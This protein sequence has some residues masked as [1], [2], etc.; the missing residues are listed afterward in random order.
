MKQSCSQYGGL[1]NGDKGFLHP[2]IRKQK[3]MRLTRGNPRPVK[4][5]DYTGLSHPYASGLKIGIN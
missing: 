1:T 5:Q 2:E 4:S 3:R